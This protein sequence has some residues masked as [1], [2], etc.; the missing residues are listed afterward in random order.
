MG[1]TPEDECLPSRV[2]A[3]HLL[4]QVRIF[5]LNLRPSAWYLH[6]T[7]SPSPSRGGGFVQGTSA[8]V[9]VSIKGH[10]NTKEQEH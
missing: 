10:D 4:N 3:C 1:V 6:P 7:P 9:V 2:W 5:S 8:S